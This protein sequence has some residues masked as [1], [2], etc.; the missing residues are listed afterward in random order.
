MLP[1]TE[2][3]IVRRKA[4]RI[5]VRCQDKVFLEH[6]SDPGAGVTWW[7]TPGGG[8]DGDETYAQAAVRELF[9][10]TGWVITEADLVGP[11]AHRF[12]S[13]GYS[14]EVLT[15][16]EQFFVVYLPEFLEAET[17]GFTDE[18][19]RTMHGSGWFTVAELS[20]IRVF[21]A[22]IT[23]FLGEKLPEFVEYGDVDESIIAL[24]ERFG[25]GIAEGQYCD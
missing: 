15:Q 25:Q 9:E 16:D 21:P 22:D 5:I 12:V 3:P 24:D 4:A 11:V 10:E 7:M 14:D 17:S 1:P 19:L 2:R 18:E 8:L 13:H 6:D 20:D 23:R